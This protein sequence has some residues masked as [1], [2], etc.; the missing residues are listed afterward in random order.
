[1]NGVLEQLDSFLSS[2]KGISNKSSEAFQVFVKQ[3]NLFFKSSHTIECVIECVSE[4][5]HQKKWTTICA[6]F[7]ECDAVI[8]ILEQFDQTFAIRWFQIAVTEQTADVFADFILKLPLSSTF[9][10]L[11]TDAEQV[12]LVRKLCH[13]HAIRFPMRGSHMNKDLL[14]V[15]TKKDKAT[16]LHALFHLSVL[17]RREESFLIDIVPES[18]YH[19]NLQD[20]FTTL[21]KTFPF[22]PHLVGDVLLYQLDSRNVHFVVDR[23]C[24]H[25]NADVEIALDRCMMPWMPWR[26]ITTQLQSFQMMFEPLY[27]HRFDMNEVMDYFLHTSCQPIDFTLFS[28]ISL[29]WL[30]D[31]QH[32]SYGFRHMLSRLYCVPFTIKQKLILYWIR[33]LSNHAKGV[34]LFL[35]T[36]LTQKTMDHF[37]ASTLAARL[38]AKPVHLWTTMKRVGPCLNQA[39][40]SLSDLEKF[41][42]DCIVILLLSFSHVNGSVEVCKRNLRCLMV[43]FE[44]FTCPLRE[45]CIPLLLFYSKTPVLEWESE[46]EKMTP[47]IAKDL[48]LFALFCKCLPMKAAKGLSCPFW[49]QYVLLKHKEANTLDHLCNFSDHIFHGPTFFVAQNSSTL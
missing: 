41:G 47:V 11:L 43:L 8:P 5:T 26:A 18:I 7:L 4:E 13:K 48:D 44:E 30:R 34:S 32:D 40:Q 14:P 17:L 28:M 12:L 10:S 35:K 22:E 31:H 15:D 33:N 19:Y 36:V 42:I 39:K 23:F 6:L 46:N 2:V 49:T 16:R 38:L 1:M 37:K 27:M 45:F 24:A 21:L 25:W 20:S 29:F 3:V 9:F